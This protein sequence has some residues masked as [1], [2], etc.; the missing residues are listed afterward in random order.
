MK[1][2]YGNDEDFIILT[3]KKYLESG[4]YC[5][6]GDMIVAPG[7]HVIG[8]IEP[9]SK[10]ANE[11]RELT[12]DGCATKL[13]SKKKLSQVTYIGFKH[14]KNWGKE[15]TGYNTTD[16]MGYAGSIGTPLDAVTMK[17][18]DGKISY[19]VHE[20]GRGWSE[21]RTGY[22]KT[23]PA[24]YAGTL[25][26]EI[27]AVAIRGINISGSLKYRAYKHGKGWGNW[28][29]GFSKTD[30]NMYAGSFGTSVDAIQI[31]IE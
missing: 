29:T 11:T 31:A 26:V 28:I 16:T 5:L 12:S 2:T 27:D 19:M 14:G 10:A 3:D 25:G 6:N 24:K 22:G 23:D 18:S 8:C 17:V 1:D 21:E 9:G 4:D 13:S 20:K 7:H 15:I 30:T